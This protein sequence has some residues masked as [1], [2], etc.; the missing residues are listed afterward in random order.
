MDY[1]EEEGIAEGVQD[2]GLKWHLDRLDQAGLPLDLLYNPIGDGQGVDVY[3]LD[4]G[5][6]YHHEEFEN[7]AKYAGYDPVDAYEEN[8]DEE[9]IPGGKFQRRFG[10]DC[11]GH[12][13][14]VASLSGGKTY[15]AAKKVTLYSIRV[16]ECDNAAPWS[17]VL[18]GLD[19]FSRVTYERG[20]PAIASL[21]LGG[22]YYQ[23]VNNAVEILYSQGLHVIVAAGNGVM[24]SCYRSPASS[25]FAMTVGGSRDGD[26][27]YTRGT[28]TN[29]GAC[30]DIFAP[31]EEI[32]SAGFSC[33]NCSVTFSG[34]SM[35]TPIVSGVAAIH[36]SRR[37]FLTPYQLQQQLINE[38]IKDALNFTGIPREAWN[39]TPNRLLNIPGQPTGLWWCCGSCYDKH[40]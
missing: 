21:S 4:S 17:T 2:E 37:P 40:L 11:H 32:T 29:Y 24:D 15:G 6:N 16:L 13:T 10:E 25:P 9:E 19:F 8:L 28:G 34:T 12:G 27:L 1:I 14:H 18:D 23:T 5:I 7:R 20:R 36:L 26:G 39:A 33:A 35:A 30:V 3:I 31:G 22:S 38:S